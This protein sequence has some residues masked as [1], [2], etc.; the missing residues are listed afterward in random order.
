M[1]HALLAI[2][3]CPKCRGPLEHVQ[4][5]EAEGLCC[6]NCDL[7]YPIEENIP[8]LLLEEALAQSEWVKSGAPSD[9]DTTV[10]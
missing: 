4:H 3:A 1:D 7:V 5:L 2:L 9:A 10:K 8:V 6:K